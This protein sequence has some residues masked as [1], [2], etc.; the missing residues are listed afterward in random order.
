MVCPACGK[1]N[2]PVAR[3]CAFC[4]ALIIHPHVPAAATLPTFPVAALV[5]L[6][7]ITFG[8]FTH[9]WLNHYH[10]KLPQRRPDDPTAGKAIGFLFIPFYNLYWLFFTY[11]RLSERLQEER[12]RYLLPDDDMRDLAMATC[13]LTVIPYF[14]IISFLIVFP[15]YAGI[16]Q[17]RINELATAR[18]RSMAVTPAVPTPMA[19]VNFCPACRLE[20]KVDAR[21]CPTCGHTLQAIIRQ[22]MQFTG[23]GWSLLGYSLVINLF[24][25][26][27]IPLAWAYTWTWKWLIRSLRLQDGTWL[28]F[29]GQPTNIWGSCALLGMIGYLAWVPY[30]LA[31]DP[32]SPGLLVLVYLLPLLL[33]PLT[34]ALTLRI[35]RSFIGNTVLSTGISFRF[36]GAYVEM[37]GWNILLYLSCFTIVGWGWAL[38]AYLRWLCDNTS[39]PDA[40]LA[41]TGQGHQLLWRGIVAYLAS[42]A[43]ISMPWAFQ[44]F[45]HWFF[46]SITV[47]QSIAPQSVEATEPLQQT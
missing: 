40:R 9:V 23:S 45:L 26:L 6:H 38:A 39:S 15:I 35:L 8:I 44:W 12:D 30:F 2:P 25:Y 47:I 36:T 14:N 21:V 11:L 29:K 32:G 1:T 42:F 13:I 20:G 5:L 22:P 16:V 7:Y 19:P 46:S 18:E 33:M 10:G 34:T 41:F 43:L 31:S 24:M 17:A 3:H 37:L 27:I 4:G 28:R